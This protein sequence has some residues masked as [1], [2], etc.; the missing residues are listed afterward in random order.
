M[1]LVALL[2]VAAVSGF[3]GYRIGTGG[4]GSDGEANSQT[5]YAV[6]D[7]IDGTSFRVTGMDVNDV[8]FRSEFDF[9]IDDATRITITWRYEP[10]DLSELEA[11]D[12]ISITFSGDILETYPAVLE[13]VTWIQ[14][15]DDEK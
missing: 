6:I 12:H 9:S 7:S 2:V 15:L 5:F 13:D 14:L 1:W 8:N 11:G 3:V 10:M 4:D